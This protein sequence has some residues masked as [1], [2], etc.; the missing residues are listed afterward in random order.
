MLKFSKKSSEGDKEIYCLWDDEKEIA[1]VTVTGNTVLKVEYDDRQTDLRYGDFTL[2]SI[3]F[4]LRDKYPI[5]ETEF[6][7]ARLKV[8]GF[9]ENNG[10]MFASS[11]K[12]NFDTCHHKG[13]EDEN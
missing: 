2:R 5:V 12:I 1:T 4:I 10:K 11:L 8:I 7:D 3:A 6:V 13:E 9:K